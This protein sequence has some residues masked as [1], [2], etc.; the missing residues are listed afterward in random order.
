MEKIAEELAEVT[1]RAAGRLAE[2]GEGEAG[3]RPAPGK[4]S[5]KEIRRA[6]P[7][8]SAA[9]FGGRDLAVCHNRID[10]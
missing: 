9:N 6:P 7:P 8:S 3:V 1:A 5:K 2:I 4:W 10:R